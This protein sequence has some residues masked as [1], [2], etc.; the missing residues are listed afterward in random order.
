MKGL[1]NMTIKCTKIVGQYHS[2][3]LPFI[4]ITIVFGEKR[5]EFV[6]KKIPGLINDRVVARLR[7]HR[8]EL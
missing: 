8:V 5:T 4:I 1:D 7:G 6:E 2:V 3:N